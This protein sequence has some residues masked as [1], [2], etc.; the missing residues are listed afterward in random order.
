[1]RINLFRHLQWQFSNAT[2]NTKQL[3]KAINTAGV[4]YKKNIDCTRGKIKKLTKEIC[5]IHSL[6]LNRNK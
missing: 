2:N 1:M 5:A 4:I 6:L 3:T